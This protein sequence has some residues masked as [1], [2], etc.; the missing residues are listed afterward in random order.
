[1]ETANS[2]TDLTKLADIAMDRLSPWSFILIPL[3][4]LG[5]LCVAYFVLLGIMWGIGRLLVL[6][7]LD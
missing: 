2:G 1:M 6:F 7:G 5:G 4:A 3:G